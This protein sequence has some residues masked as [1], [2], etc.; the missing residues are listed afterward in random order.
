MEGTTHNFVTLRLEFRPHAIILP[1]WH[2]HH[3][4]FYS[5]DTLPYVGACKLFAKVIVNRS[6]KN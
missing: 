3:H 1:R 5:M 6:Q 4:H 2:A